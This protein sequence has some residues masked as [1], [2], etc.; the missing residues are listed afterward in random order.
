M[1][2]AELVRIPAGAAFF[3]LAAL[4]VRRRAKLPGERPHR[5]VDHA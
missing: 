4:M 3:L 1:Q 2:Q 5:Q